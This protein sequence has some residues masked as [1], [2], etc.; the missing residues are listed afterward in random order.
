[1]ARSL[2]RRWRDAFEQAEARRVDELLSAHRDSFDAA[3]TAIGAQLVDATT[4]LA[5]GVVAGHDGLVLEVVADGFAP[6]RLFGAPV[7]DG[8]EP[9]AV[10]LFA[11]GRCR[12]CGRAAP[13][14]PGVRFP[15]TSATQAEPTWGQ[16]LATGD[17]VHTCGS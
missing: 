6:A 1:M 14:R 7:G 15:G 10:R 12:E 17:A 2:E 13:L 16:A 9:G 4:P 3:V 5:A 11:I 8:A